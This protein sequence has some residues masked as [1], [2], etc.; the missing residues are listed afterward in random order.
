MASSRVSPKTCTPP[1]STASRAARIRT[2]SGDSSPETYSV[3]TP[4]CSSRAAYCSSRVDLPIPGSPPTNTTDPGTI[5]PPS[6]KSNSRRPVCQRCTAVVD[7]LERRTGRTS[8]GPRC[9]PR[10]PAAVRP[11]TSSTSEF[12]AP[13]ASQ[14]PPHFGCSAPHSLQRNT[15]LPLATGRLGGGFAGRVIVEPRVLLL[16]EQLDRPGGPVALLPDDQFRDALDALVGL[17]IDGAVVEFLPVDEAHDVRVLL[18]GSRL[19]QVG[20]LRAT[21]LPATLLGRARQL[22]QRE[23]RHVELLGE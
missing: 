23:H 18:D 13:Q 22:G 10:S 7:K 5:P 21:V 20:E 15:E 9:H 4:A 11:R 2:C 3:D 17:R 6:T 14:R 16:E 12:H 1:A 19:T 8:S